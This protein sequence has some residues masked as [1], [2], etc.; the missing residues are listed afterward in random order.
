MFR[1]SMT[2]IYLLFYQAFIPV[3]NKF[4]L[5]LQY[6]RI[7]YVAKMHSQ[8][9]SLR[10]T[11]W[12]SLSKTENMAAV[13]VLLDIDTTAEKSATPDRNQCIYCICNQTKNYSS[14]V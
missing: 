13:P 11:F 2:E 5:F 8:C 6:M 9:H 4:N 3:S 1:E 12:E 7:A 10:K 14:G